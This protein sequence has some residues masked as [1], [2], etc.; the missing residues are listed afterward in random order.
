MKSQSTAFPL[1]FVLSVGLLAWSALVAPAAHAST[2]WTGP[3]TNYVE[4]GAGAAD[5]LIPGAVSLAR[6]T[7]LWLYNTNVD[8]FG[9]GTGTPSDTE[10]A[11]GT[12]D[13]F[14]SLTY[15]SFSDIR[16]DASLSGQNLGSYL[17]T[18]G[19]GGGAKPMVVHLI[20]QDI[21]L[22]LIFTSWPPSA[23]GGFGYNRSTPAAVVAPQPTVSITNPT[24]NTTLAA[25]AN[26]TV[27]ANASVSGGG[28]VTN[29]TFFDGNTLMGSR[30]T[31]PFN[32]TTN[33]LG[34]RSYAFTAVA[35]AAGISATSTV[36][37]V[38]VV[39]PVVTTLAG[40]AAANNQ[41]SFNYTANPG[42]RY[43]V[44]SSS[45]LLNW[46]PVVT[47]VASGSPVPFTN[48]ILPGD[49]FYR[50][51]RLPNL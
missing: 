2:F 22:S 4:P 15:K 19:P 29:V 31:P 28:T 38:S 18:G 42:L 40:S 11:F 41:F 9:A 13:Q 21:Y 39:A 8:V 48:T 17:T 6:G 43:V 24:N 20:N 23:G 27:V 16:T 34:A 26:V 35:T 25:P 33:N 1:G 51:G 45:N 47:N 49:S 50:V 44:E 7:R 30:P 10:W 12:I 36:V 37:N 32:L 14:N 46:T 5:V 3:T